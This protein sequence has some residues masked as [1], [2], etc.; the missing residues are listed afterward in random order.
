MIVRTMTVRIMMMKMM[1]R[2]RIEDE[3]ECSNHR[4]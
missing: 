2:I 4:R 1:R 3:E